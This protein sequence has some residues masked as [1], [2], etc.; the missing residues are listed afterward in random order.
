MDEGRR[1]RTEGR[2]LRSKGILEERIKNEREEKR[3]KD[4]GEGRRRALEGMLGEER[5]K[6]GRSVWK[7]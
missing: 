1:K 4:M 7:T 6:E 2:V 5:K 3:R